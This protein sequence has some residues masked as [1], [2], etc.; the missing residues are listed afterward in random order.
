MEKYQQ[1]EYILQPLTMRS[2]TTASLQT[3]LKAEFGPLRSIFIILPASVTKGKKSHRQVYA[4]TRV[5]SE[6][7]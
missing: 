3:Q 5:F 4:G 2:I 6:N 1:R 7:C